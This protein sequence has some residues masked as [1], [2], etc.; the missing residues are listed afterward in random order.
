MGD[1]DVED[2]YER[3]RTMLAMSTV[4]GEGRNALNR[5]LDQTDKGPQPRPRRLYTSYIPYIL[6]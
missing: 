6:R 3:G 4:Y 2:L 1:V 5:S